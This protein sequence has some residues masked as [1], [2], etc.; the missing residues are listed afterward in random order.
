M[1][2]L[3]DI[4]SYCF[5]GR[6]HLAKF[7]LRRPL[8]DPTSLALY[9]DSNVLPRQMQELP[10]HTKEAFCQMPFGIS[11]LFNTGQVILLVSQ[12]SSTFG[13]KMDYVFV[14]LQFFAKQGA[15]KAMGPFVAEMC[16]PYCLSLVVTPVSDIEAEW[17]YILLKEFS[18]CLKHKAVKALI[19]HAIQTILQASCKHASK[20][21]QLKVSILQD[22]YVREIWH[23]IGKQAYLETIHPSVISNLYV[24][25]HKSSTTAASML[26]IVSSEEFGVPVTV[27]QTILSLIHCFGKGVCSDGINVLVRIGG[28]LEENFVDGSCLHVMV[29][30][31]TSLDTAVLQNSDKQTEGAEY[32][33]GWIQA[34]GRPNLPKPKSKWSSEHADKP[35]KPNSIINNPP[36]SSSTWAQPIVEMWSPTLSNAEGN[37]V[38]PKLHETIL[39]N[40]QGVLYKLH[41]LHIEAMGIEDIPPSAL[42]PQMEKTKNK[43]LALPIILEEQ[44]GNN[45]W[46]LES[47]EH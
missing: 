8:F 21:L 26:L 19:L 10:S 35:I 37:L 1:T 20:Y 17:E 15:F 12:P 27:H 5:G 4:K 11:M 13:K 34:L 39:G 41:S 32:E 24:S 3:W 36:K 46:T 42:T 7:H 38:T 9:L 47:V 45:N 40:M 2:L 43:G 33:M 18:K 29:L 23:W 25:P 14:M 44:T 22:S 30:M 31:Q 6:N 16:A 28:L